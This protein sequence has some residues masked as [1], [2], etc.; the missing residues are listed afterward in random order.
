MGWIRMPQRGQETITNAG[1]VPHG[2]VTGLVD[3]VLS[4]YT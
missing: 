2:V 3:R 1:K 4:P